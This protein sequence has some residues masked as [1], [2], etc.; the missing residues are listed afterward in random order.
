MLP[1]V[2]TPVLS[3]LHL[4]RSWKYP[5]PNTPKGGSTPKVTL[6]IDQLETLMSEKFFSPGK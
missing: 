3:K 5:P 2:V 6:M 4:R 1:R